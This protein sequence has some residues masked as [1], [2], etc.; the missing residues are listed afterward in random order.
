MR[1][2][3]FA[4]LAL[5]SPLSGLVPAAHAADGRLEIHQ[6]CVATGCFPGDA[7]GFPVDIAASGSYLLT[8]DLVVTDAGPA[9]IRIQGNELAL[10]IDLNQFTISGP[11]RCSLGTCSPNGGG[12]IFNAGA[13]SQVNVLNGRILGMGGMGVSLNGLGRVEGV[14]VMHSHWGI[15]GAG[16]IRANVVA[17]CGDIGILCEGCVAVEN[18]V[19]YN[20]GDGV[21]GS[22]HAVVRDSLVSS[23]G[24]LGIQGGA[25]VSYGGNRLTDNNGGNANPQVSAGSVEV[26]P[27]QCGDDTV[28]P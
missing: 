23:N 24:G 26:G 17:F 13:G 4:L 7:P 3:G 8:S 18:V 16:V 12:G 10:T 22:F 15:V 2:M 20:G 9:A 6:A 25:G 11:T 28:C 19:R 27:N 21:W 1:R 5:A 14:T